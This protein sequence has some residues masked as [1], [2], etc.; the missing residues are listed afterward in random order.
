MKSCVLLAVARGK[1]GHAFAFYLGLPVDAAAELPDGR[2]FTDIR[3]FKRLVREDDVVLA[4][5]LVRQFLVYGTRA[6]VRFSDRPEIERILA[7]AK[8]TQYGVRT[9]VHTIVQSDLF[10]SK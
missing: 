10:L 4:R 6:P 1:N 9:L 2:P 5:N 8:P 7:Q 3:G